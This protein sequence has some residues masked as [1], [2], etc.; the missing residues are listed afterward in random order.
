M[1]QVGRCEIKEM[2]RSCETL[3]PALPD[4]CRELSTHVKTV[5]ALVISSHRV[6]AYTAVQ[7]EDPKAAA[8]LWREYMLFCEDALNCLRNAKEKFPY[9][10]AVNAYDVTLDYWESAKERFHENSQDAEWQSKTPS[11]LSPGQSGKP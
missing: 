11:T 6:V 2:Q 10:A 3:D 7:F 1:E 9:C 5:E 4:S 8:D